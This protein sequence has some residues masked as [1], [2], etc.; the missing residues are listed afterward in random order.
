MQCLLLG[1]VA[2]PTVFLLRG[3]QCAAFLTAALAAGTMTLHLRAALHAPVVSVVHGYDL[4]STV[5]IVGL[6]VFK[7]LY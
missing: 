7:P 3:T 2:V 6:M 1:I 5:V 4:V